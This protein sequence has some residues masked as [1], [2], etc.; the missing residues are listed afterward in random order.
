[1]LEHQGQ[2]VGPEACDLQSDAWCILVPKSVVWVAGRALRDQS[3]LGIRASMS[4]VLTDFRGAK[5]L[6]VFNFFCAR[7]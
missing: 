4:D 2:R 7:S 5:P 1:M 3:R 6:Q